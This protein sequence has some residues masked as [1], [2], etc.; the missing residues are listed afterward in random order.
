MHP[1]NYDF[2]ISGKLFGNTNPATG[3]DTNTE[4]KE[5]RIGIYSDLVK[6]PEDLAKRIT[7]MISEEMAQGKI[8]RFSFTVSIRDQLAQKYI[9]VQ[10]CLLYTSPSPRDQRGSRMPSSA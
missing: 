4:L 2:S 5:P 6:N 9:E 10:I 3:L 8:P 1:S 7:E